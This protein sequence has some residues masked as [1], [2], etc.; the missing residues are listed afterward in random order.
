MTAEGLV[1][2]LGQLGIYLGVD[3]AS[4]W[5]EPA[6]RLTPDLQEAI[7]THKSALLMLLNAAN[8]PPVAGRLIRRVAGGCGWCGGTRF[9]RSQWKVT[10]A[11]CYPPA[12]PASVVEWLDRGT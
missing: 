11:R 3:G 8:D 2:R 5:A 7:R 12:N 10:C 6:R 1:E 4:L 9:W